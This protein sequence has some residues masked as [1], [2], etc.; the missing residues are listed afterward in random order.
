MEFLEAIEQAGPVRLLKVSFVVYPIVNALHIAAIGMLFASVVLLDLR[1]LGAL[2]SLPR[3]AFVT[4]FRRIALYAFATAVATGLAL[5]AV[6]ASEYAAMPAFLLKMGLIGAA[7]ANFLGFAAIESRSA[8]VD[9][10]PPALRISAV[11]S[12]L[13]WSSVLLCGRFLGFL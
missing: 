6:R 7:I 8:G 3:Q 12:V 5:F 1:L 9:A 11:V 4:A 2:A 13:L 10:A